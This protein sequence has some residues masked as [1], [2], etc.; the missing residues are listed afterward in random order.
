A[1]ALADWK[2]KTELQSKDIDIGIRKI[3]PGLKPGEY[4]TSDDFDGSCFIES[5]NYQY[6]VQNK[7]CSTRISGVLI[8][9]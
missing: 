4:V 1:K 7:N 6:N 9:A 8:D 2:V 3:I 5:I